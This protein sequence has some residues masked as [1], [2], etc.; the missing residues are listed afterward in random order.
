MEFYDPVQKYE[1]INRREEP[2]HRGSN[3]VD[4][5]TLTLTVDVGRMTALSTLCLALTM[6]V[7]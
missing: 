7:Q 5:L 1:H 3:L 2:S 6:D 4:A